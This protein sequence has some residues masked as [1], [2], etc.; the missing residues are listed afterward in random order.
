MPHAHLV[1][2]R[3][4][5][6]IGRRPHQKKIAL[7]KNIS[8]T[9]AQN[10]CARPLHWQMRILEF[11]FAT[12]TLKRSRFRGGALCARIKRPG[13]RPKRTA[14]TR[15]GAGLGIGD[16]TERWSRTTHLPI[17]RQGPG[18]QCERSWPD[19]SR[20]GQVFPIRRCSSPKPGE[21]CAAQKCFP[22]SRGVWYAFLAQSGYRV[23]CAE[24][25]VC[26]ALPQVL[27]LCCPSS[28]ASSTRWSWFAHAGSFG[29]AR[30]PRTLHKVALAESGRCHL[31]RES[32]FSGFVDG[33]I[34]RQVG[35]R[36]STGMRTASR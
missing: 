9:C 32:I 33:Q 21:S 30:P 29:G 26:D 18:A 15:C 2:I 7:S 24:C 36:W 5:T 14:N 16:E 25:G 23:L 3:N 27:C 6:C 1:G 4:F 35:R 31:S 19:I 12:F 10:R 8:C 13:Q 17:G 22:T 11:C 28:Q 34:V 20:V